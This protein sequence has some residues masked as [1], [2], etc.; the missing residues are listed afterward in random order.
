MRIIFVRKEINNKT[1]FN[2]FSSSLS[3]FDVRSWHY[4]DACVWFCWR[5]TRMCCDLFTSRG[6]YMR[7][8]AVVNEQSKTDTKEKKLLNKLFFI[9][10][11]SFY[12]LVHKVFS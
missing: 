1:L 9:I 6:M 11:T 4:N 10:T 5:W 2:D 12:F 3:V 8:G 7:R